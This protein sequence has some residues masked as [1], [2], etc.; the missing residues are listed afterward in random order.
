[1]K[2]LKLILLFVY[3]ITLTACSSNNNDDDGNTPNS[4]Y[5]ISFE[6]NDKKVEYTTV[7]SAYKYD[8]LA[9]GLY[10]VGVSGADSNNALLIYLYDTAQISTGNYTGEIIPNKYISKA[11]VSYGTQT[12]GFT[13]AAPNISS[14]AYANVSVTEINETYIAGVF[15]AALVSNSDYSTITHTIKNGKFKIKFLTQ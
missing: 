9:N 12:E 6:V 8:D 2:T 15:N 10:G 5:Y 4:E 7:I 13:S 11:I 14:V 1:M 3:I